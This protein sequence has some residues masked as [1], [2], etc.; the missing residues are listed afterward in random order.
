MRNRIIRWWVR[1]KLNRKVKMKWCAKS[2]E[3]I[4]ELLIRQA[5]RLDHL[6]ETV[7]MIQKVHSGQIGYLKL[8]VREADQHIYVIQKELDL[9]P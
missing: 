7:L 9:G 8:K 4:L 3:Q 2:R 6:E 1:R 5:A